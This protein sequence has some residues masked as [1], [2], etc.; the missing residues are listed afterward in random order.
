MMADWLGGDC[1]SHKF[2]VAE[3]AILSAIGHKFAPPSPIISS[4]R[5]L[6]VFSN[7]IH[8]IFES[9]ERVCHIES[10][11]PPSCMSIKHGQ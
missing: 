3:W 9:G 8:Q 10:G 11:L 2:G 1:R 4:V 7:S 6:A 5:S